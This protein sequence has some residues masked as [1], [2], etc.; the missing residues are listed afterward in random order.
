MIHLFGCSHT[1][2]L[3]STHLKN[4]DVFKNHSVE[5]NSNQKIIS[6]VYK[7]VN[8]KSFNL[9]S[10]VLVIQYT[11]TNRWW[12]ENILPFPNAGF[13]SL[14]L[15]SPIYNEEVNKSYSSELLSFYET[16]LKFFW[17]YELSLREHIMNIELLKSFLDL[18]KVKYIHYM[19]SDG[20][21]NDELNYISKSTNFNDN[22]ID[23]TL[24][25]LG[26]MKVENNFIIE[27]WAKNNNYLD[28][29]NHISS[30]FQ[31]ILGDKVINEIK[32]SFG[33]NFL[34]KVLI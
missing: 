30:E 21:N 3:Y 4:V 27:Q 22:E 14:S 33:K 31:N 1:K 29:T 16:F 20:C 2:V 28:S 32:K 12:R 13:H 11:Y 6:D 25:N 34:K 26:L 23:N 17:D 10:D 19:F 7:F 8:S 18:K 15:D 24:N 5:G 9:E